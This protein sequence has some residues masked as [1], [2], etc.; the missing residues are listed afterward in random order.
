MVPFQIDKTTLQYIQRPIL[1]GKYSSKSIRMIDLKTFS[2]IFYTKNKKVSSDWVSETQPNYL[3]VN[4][5]RFP[6]NDSVKYVISG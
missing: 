6:T 1:F 4:P 3:I 5:F 2:N